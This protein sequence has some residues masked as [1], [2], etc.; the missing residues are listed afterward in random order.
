MLAL[1]LLLNNVTVFISQK[2]ERK[3]KRDRCGSARHFNSI[4]CHPTNPRGCLKVKLM[5]Q[6]FCDTSKDIQ[7]ILWEMK[8]IGNVNYLLTRIV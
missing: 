1:L 4:C 7:S 6:V 5:E 2:K 3:T 8:T